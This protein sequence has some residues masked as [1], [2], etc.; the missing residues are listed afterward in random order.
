MAGGQAARWR[1][2]LRE[3]EVSKH[4]RDM[5]REELLALRAMTIQRRAAEH[6]FADDAGR[7]W[8][9]TPGMGEPW[10]RVYVGYDLDR[11]I[12]P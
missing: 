9:V 3:A 5:T 8:N 12:E 6:S 4:P 10:V 11:R 1:R 2:P 7:F